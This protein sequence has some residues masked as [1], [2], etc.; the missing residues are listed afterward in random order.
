MRFLAHIQHAQHT[1]NNNTLTHKNKRPSH[2]KN[3]HQQI[4]PEAWGG[5]VLTLAEVD[6]LAAYAPTQ[7]GAG[8]MLW[9]LHKKGTPSPQQ[10]L[11]RACGL[12]GM[13]DCAAALPM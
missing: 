4:P 7:G 5:N 13:A 6:D 8:L 3:N 2:P 11:Q 1:C 10:V 12:Q 9:S